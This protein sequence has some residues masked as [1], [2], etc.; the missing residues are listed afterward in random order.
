MLVIPAIDLMGGEAVRLEKGDFATKTVYAR[1]PAEKAEEFARA[2]ATLL[3]VVD[4]D[5][6][7][8]GWPVNLD[9][10]R[11]ICEVPGIEVELGG[12]L[13]S[14]PDIEKVLALGVRYVVLGT[15]AVERLGL[16]EQACQRFP[17]QVRAGID[18]RNGEVKI[19]GW[20]E[21]TGL[22][23]VDVA[24]KVKGAGVGL[25]E[26]TDVARDG[27]FTGVDAAGAARIQ[28]E[29][30]IPVVASGGV[31]SLDDVTACRAAGLA[32]VIVG[33]ALYE[34]RIDLAAAIR[35]AAA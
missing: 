10:V 26:Y 15:A 7:K 3:H 14:L 18:A 31:A 5:G 22:A 17:G 13:R 33:K 28:A 27:M 23:A 34:R 2:G 4:L 9:A 16:V 35:A 30:G 19:A 24:R 29:A 25:V 8:A 6:A 12:G 11:A 20:L 21:G 32:G 1:H